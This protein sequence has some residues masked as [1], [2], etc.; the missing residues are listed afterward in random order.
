MRHLSR[1]RGRPDAS[2][3][4]RPPAQSPSPHRFLSAP[5][6]GW[7]LGRIADCGLEWFACV[8]G[9]QEMLPHLD[10]EPRV[11]S[12]SEARPCCFVLRLT[13]SLAVHPTSQRVRVPCAACGPRR[14]SRTSCNCSTVHSGPD[15]QPRESHRRTTGGVTLHMAAAGR[16]EMTTSCRFTRRTLAGRSL[17]S[18]NPDSDVAPGPLPA[19]TDP[20]RQKP[21]RL[22]ATG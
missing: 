8:D 5:K 21:I 9:V 13:A 22:S 17:T 3:S 10:G 12:V 15:Y 16:I 6:P 7:R 11:C 1:A 2:R 20:D 14:R 4:K 18:L 19:N